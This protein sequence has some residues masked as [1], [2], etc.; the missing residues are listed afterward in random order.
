M[1]PLYKGWKLL[2]IMDVFTQMKLN[3]IHKFTNENHPNKLLSL[4]VKLRQDT[5][6]E[7]AAN[8]L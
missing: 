2:Q 7:V 5:A 3:K 6:L 4:P 1:E 8:C